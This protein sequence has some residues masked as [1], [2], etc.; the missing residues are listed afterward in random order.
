M[1]RN[2]FEIF[3]REHIFENFSYNH[4]VFPELQKCENPEIQEFFSH[5][6]N[7]E[8]NYKRDPQFVI[9]LINEQFPS[10][11]QYYKI[12]L[13]L[14][15]IFM[16]V[17]D[18][19][20]TSTYKKR[21]YE[22]FAEKYLEQ[23]K[24]SEQNCESTSHI[25][26]LIDN[27]NTD[28]NIKE[29]EKN[30]SEYDDSN[31]LLMKGNF[32]SREKIDEAL[33]T[34]KD[35]T[36]IFPDDV[37]FNNNLA[38]MY[39]ANG[40]LN[41]AYDTLS[42][43]L[44]RNQKEIRINRSTLYNNL[45]CI[46]SLMDEKDKAI[47]YF[48]DSISNNKKNFRAWYNSG[49]F[50]NSHNDLRQGLDC[51]KKAYLQNKTHP[52]IGIHYVLSLLEN[53]KKTRGLSIFKRLEPEENELFT[54][55]RRMIDGNDYYDKD[56]FY[57]QDKPHSEMEFKIKSLID[58]QHKILKNLEKNLYNNHEKDAQLFQRVVTAMQ[59]RND[60]EARILSNELAEIRKV[61]KII[62]ADWGFISRINLSDLKIKD[63]K[64]LGEI[65]LFLI[66]RLESIIKMGKHLSDDATVKQIELL[67]AKLSEF[68][69][70]K[71]LPTIESKVLSS[72]EFK[73]F[74]NPIT[75][76]YVDE[77]VNFLEGSTKEFDNFRRKLDF[78]NNLEAEYFDR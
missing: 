36:K 55:A 60:K 28:N 38:N 62:E 37:R 72:P 76:I 27:E 30:F 47:Q 29:C 2:Q 11:K 1:T 5:C 46:C 51:F 3:N 18:S 43:T 4:D 69:Q 64:E 39:V 19:L 13:F 44:N 21:T 33:Q 9:E 75:K 66:T 20:S 65:G 49:I 12:Q 42:G 63:I 77:T 71:G 31:F 68:L 23:S 15:Q 17:A 73:K 57:H 32:E 67:R 26:Y 56:G 41:S 34:F 50:H 70:D 61:T 24:Q 22:K 25:S 16:D 54:Q 7:E 45:G 6:K 59:E 53:G 35:G 52:K 74:G 8:I 58:I 40:D 78:Q 10:T 14:S 48:L